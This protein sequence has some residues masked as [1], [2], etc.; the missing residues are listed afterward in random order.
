MLDCALFKA[1]DLCL[2][3]TDLGGDLHLRFAVVKAHFDDRALAWGKARERLA[4]SDILDPAVLGYIGVGEL[5]ND[6]DRVLTVVVDRFVKRYG[7]GNRLHGR[8]RVR[9]S[10]SRALRAR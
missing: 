5:V 2:A 4:Q 8:R 3:D 1:G 6:I 9:A 7:R 10:V